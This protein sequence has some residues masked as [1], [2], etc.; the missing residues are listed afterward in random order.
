MDIRSWTLFKQKEYDDMIL[1]K[2][3][4]ECGDDN[5]TQTLILEYD[6]HVD[7][8]T[9]SISGKIVAGVYNRYWIAR[10]FKRIW[11]SLKMLFTGH[12]EAEGSVLISGADNIEHMHHGLL[13]GFNKMKNFENQLEKER[14]ND[15]S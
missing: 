3:H 4:C 12:L 11:L 2:A 5:H 1:Y 7:M 14:K 15:N 10:F 8:I 6:D 9:M 13:R